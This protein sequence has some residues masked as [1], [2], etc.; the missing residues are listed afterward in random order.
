MRDPA[1]TIPRAVPLALGIVLGIYLVVGFV[2]LAVL[3]PS[4]LARSRAPLADV[5]SAAGAGN[6]TWIVRAAARTSQ[7]P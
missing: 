6:F 3:G 5:V 2:T 7:A 1:R 4:R